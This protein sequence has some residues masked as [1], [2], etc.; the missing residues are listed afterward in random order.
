MAA[1]P[2]YA[3]RIALAVRLGHP[4]AR[5]LGIAPREP[6]IHYE[7]WAKLPEDL[8]AALRSGLPPRLCLVWSLACAE[9]IL[10]VF[11]REFHLDTRP[12]Q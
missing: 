4:A 11:E 7:H 9:R 12:R 8:R 2:D 5:A 10:P 3:E 1:D 6:L